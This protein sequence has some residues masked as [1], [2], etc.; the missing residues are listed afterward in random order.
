MVV[1]LALVPIVVDLPNRWVDGPRS[2]VG[3]VAGPG[4]AQ[5]SAN[6]RLPSRIN[7]LL[8]GIQPPDPERPTEWT[9]GRPRSGDD[10]RVTKPAQSPR[11]RSQP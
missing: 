2:K 6:D 11:E 1:G 5:T 7:P 8:T 3:Q 10:G 4:G 9:R